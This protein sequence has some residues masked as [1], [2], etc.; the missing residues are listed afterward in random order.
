MAPR[1]EVGYNPCRDCSDESPPTARTARCC[2]CRS[3]TLIRPGKWPECAFPESHDI[4]RLQGCLRGACSRV[5]TK[6][7]AH[8][9]DR[10][11]C[12]NGKCTYCNTK[13]PPEWRVS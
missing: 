10:L 4:S 13:S 5:R 6:N 11:R 3:V 8:Y 2:D 12:V 1:S 9:R 7:R